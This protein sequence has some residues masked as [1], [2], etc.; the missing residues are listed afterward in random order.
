MMRLLFKTNVSLSIQKK[1]ANRYSLTVLVYYI[2]SL[3]FLLFVQ[4]LLLQY[5]DT[6]DH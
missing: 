2:I 4:P 1:T 5:G 3:L 6:L